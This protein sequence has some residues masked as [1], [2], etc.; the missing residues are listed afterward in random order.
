MAEVSLNF[1]HDLYAY[2]NMSGFN[3]TFSGITVSGTS[4]TGTTSLVF[5]GNG[6]MNGNFS[7]SVRGLAW[8]PYDQNDRYSQPISAS[9]SG[10]YSTSCATGF[11]EG[12]GASPQEHIYIWINIYPRL[13]ISG[14]T[15]TCEGVMLTA[16]NGCSPVHTWEVSETL[17]GTYRQIPGQTA[18]S[19]FITRQQLT[20]L[21]FADP[22][23]QKYFRV[24]G[25]TGTTSLIQ[26]MDISYPPPT[27]SI[28]TVDPTCHDGSDGAIGIKIISPYTSLINDFVLTLFSDPELKTYLRQ[29]HIENEFQ[30]SFTGLP[31]GKYWL[32][33]ENN[34][35]IGVYGN[36]WAVCE[37]NAFD[38]PRRALTIPEF[39]ASDYNGFNIQC[40]GGNNGTIKAI[41]SGG[42]G[43]YTSYEWIPNVSNTD[44]AINLSAGSYKVKVT[45]SNG[46]RSE[47]FS[48]TL[49]APEKLVVEL[50]STGGKNGFDIS[51]HD[52]K[53]GIVETNASGGVATYSYTWSDGSAQPTLAGV[54]AG[55][56]SLVLTDRNGCTATTSTTLAAP[57]PIDFTIAELTGINCAG[58]LTG[59]LEVQS[60][61]NTIGTPYYSWSSGESHKEISN[62]SAGTY[63]ATV[64]DDQG[65]TATKYHTLVEPKPWSIE[66][67]TLSDYNGMAVRCQGESNA[68]LTTVLKDGDNNTAMAE[69]YTWYRNGVQINS[70][71]DLSA[72][73]GLGAGTYKAEITYRTHCRAE[74]S[75]VLAEPPPVT[76]TIAATSNY[77][78]A[79]ISCYGRADGSIHASASGG[80]GNAYTYAWHSGQTTQAVANLA[81]GTYMVTASDINGCQGVGKI[82]LTDPEP[83]EA[84]VQVVSDYNGQPIS[85]A[86]ASD[87]SLS[88]SASGGVSLF[89]FS[90][91]T[92]AKSAFLKDIPA[93]QY[94]VKATDAN[95]CEG[96]AETTITGPLPINA[97]ITDA[98]DFNGFGVSCQGSADGYLSCGATGGTGDYS[99]RWNNGSHAAPHLASIP[100]GEYTVVVTDENDCSASAV[101]VITAPE[102]LTLDAAEIK[103]VSCNGGEDG[104]IRLVAT[105]GAGDY[106]FTALRETWQRESLLSRLQAGPYDPVVRD[107]NG[108]TQ[109][110]SAILTEPAPLSIRFDQIEPALCGD[111]KGKVSAIVTGGRGDYLFDWTDA[112]NT[113]IANT[114]DVSGL[115]SGVYQ[116]TVTDENLCL[117]MGSVGI[118]STDGPKVRVSNIVSA[119]CSYSAN[120]SASV[121]ITAGYGPFTFLWED[122]QSSGEAVA[123]AKG[124]HLVT[125]TDANN[126]AVVESITI[127]APD[128][129]L[130]HLLE[131]VEPQC[132]GDCNGELR[133]SASGGS[134]EYNFSWDQFNGPEARDLCQ[135]QYGVKVSDENGCLGYAAYTL[136]QPDPVTIALISA[137]DPRCPDGCDGRLEVAARGG[138]DLLTY[139]WS[140]GRQGPAIEGLCPGSYTISVQTATIVM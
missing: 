137:K 122:G 93:G 60:I 80:T 65:C 35:N 69:Y 75:L 109:V 117:A 98:S 73:D 81:A 88:V 43:T 54:G 55:T 50:F 36:C 24:A 6:L 27:A 79:T 57:E 139:H 110:T 131:K 1:T 3:F 72:L 21:G 91:N 112:D 127:P 8:E 136:G 15:D 105:G 138:S 2:E 31:A 92:G 30:S 33:I 25:K 71:Q 45:D 106:E 115:M 83:V 100:A 68:A 124:D 23:G 38:K 86:N 76:A 20:A 16:V 13:E 101:G 52:K 4:S 99:Y 129:L 11:F 118:T 97:R 85:C 64:S 126:C 53:D 70:G 5:K 89:T 32:K 94:S 108:C 62:K 132:H 67:V 74:K 120:G 123:L 128:T 49:Q 95:G 22:F 119:T 130:V 90:W 135:G 113:V 47:A 102:P 14:F 44:I 41:P 104:A 26:K 66:I 42:T 7:M 84:I 37:S 10:T 40:N 63:A 134:G 121:E 39:E 111:P 56:Y 46:C 116:L 17:G 140:D 29:G 133:V 125:V 61:R 12:Q 107:A 82:V 9:Y 28:S 103:N 34:S 59:V 114:P 51:C 18:S 58:Y 78:G 77:N 48:K 19:I 96:E 87:A